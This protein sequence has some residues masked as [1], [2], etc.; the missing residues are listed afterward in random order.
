VVGG[1]GLGVVGRGQVAQGAVGS[2][3]VVLDPPVLDQYLGLEQAAEGLD[4]EQL[5]AQ[6]AAEALHLASWPPRVSHCSA[7]QPSSYERRAIGYS[8]ARL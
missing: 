7:L 2:D 5:V 4:G 6:P 8:S 3:G 1:P